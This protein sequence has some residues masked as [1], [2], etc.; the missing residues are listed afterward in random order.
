LHH[1]QSAARFLPCLEIVVASH[2]QAQRTRPKLIDRQPGAQDLDFK[3]MAGGG[4]EAAGPSDEAPPAASKR[5]GAGGGGSVTFVLE[6]A[7]LEVA[8]VGKSYELLNCDD[9]SGFLRRHDK[10]PAHYRPDICHQASAATSCLPSSRI[11]A[12]HCVMQCNA[13]QIY[14]DALLPSDRRHCWPSWTAR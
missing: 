10:D 11:S 12:A 6:G 7:N 14:F 2:A 8:K 4:I 13:R 9:H 1:K 3:H 5:G